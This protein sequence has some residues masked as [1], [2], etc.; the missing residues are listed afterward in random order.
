MFVVE[1][2]EESDVA[3]SEFEWVS[4]LLTLNNLF[5][6]WEWYMRMSQH[7]MNL[8]LN[9]AQKHLLSFERVLVLLSPLSFLFLQTKLTIHLSSIYDRRWLNREF[10][11]APK[12]T[13]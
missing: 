10:I 11:Q 13:R 5:V 7:I 6:V 8:S 9:I 2:L 4:A 3:L 12:Q 1:M